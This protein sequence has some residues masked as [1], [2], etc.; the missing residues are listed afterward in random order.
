MKEEGRRIQTLK[1]SK[2]KTT[3]GYERKGKARVLPYE[4]GDV[5][6]IKRR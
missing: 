4:F 1:K 5:N 2:K 3:E 6:I